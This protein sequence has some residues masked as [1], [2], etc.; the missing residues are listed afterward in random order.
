M[1][2]FPVWL[3]L[4]VAPISL[5]SAFVPLSRF[6]NPGP[7]LTKRVTPSFST[8]E[9]VT[10]TEDIASIHSSSEDEILTD[11]QLKL[12]FKVLEKLRGTG[13]KE[14]HDSVVKE[15]DAD[16]HE[17]FGTQS[18]VE[19]MDAPGQD[20]T[21]EALAE[22]APALEVEENDAPT[23]NAIID[24]LHKVV[25]LLIQSRIADAVPE[26]SYDTYPRHDEVRK[27]SSSR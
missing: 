16:A 24:L 18:I 9:D 22:V 2:V 7:L 6:A 26:L 8:T 21:P 23:K 14:I 25:K 11:R 12:A 3:L 19:E 10:V 13:V 1:Q 27:T 20:V 17:F 4:A 15:S 5:A